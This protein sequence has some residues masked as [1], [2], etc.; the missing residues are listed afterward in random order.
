MTVGVEVADAAAAVDEVIA[1]AAA[2]GGQLYDSSL[3]LTDPLTA[4]GD[5]VFKL[6]P[7][8]GGCLPDGPRT[9]H[10]AAYRPAGHHRAMSPPSSPISMRRSSPP[11]R[12][13]SGCGRCSRPAKD[14]GEVITLEGE[15]STRETHLEQLLAQQ[16]GLDGQVAMATH[17]RAPH[18]GAGRS[19]NDPGGG[20][21]HRCRVPLRL[22][23]VPVGD[24]RLRAVRRLHGTVHAD[25][26]ARA[27]RR[28]ARQPPPAGCAV[29]KSISCST[30]PTS[31]GRRSA[32][33]VHL[34]A[35]TRPE[36]PEIGA[37]RRAHALLPRLRRAARRAIAAGPSP[38]ATPRPTRRRTGGR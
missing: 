32:Y 25:R 21:G 24:L 27:A 2:H 36:P 22:E 13:S 6:P 34:V 18:D 23:G 29:T 28:V 14:L 11:R 37:E 10:R 33:V 17:H 7:A 3:D 15:L 26:C 30:A 5:L 4:A 12:A 8:R 38:A 19:S 31:S 20:Q 16:S 1:L 9:G 35:Q